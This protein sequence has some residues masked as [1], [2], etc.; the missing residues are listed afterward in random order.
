MTRWPG[1]PGAV[2]LLQQQFRLRRPAGA[3]GDRTG[4]APAALALRGDQ[5]GRRTP[6]RPL[7]HELRRAHQQPALLHG[8]RPPPAAGHGLPQVHRGGPGRA[9]L[10]GLRRRLARPATS[11]TWATRC[12]PTCWRW[13]C[14]EAWEVF[15]TGGGSRVV[16]QRGPGHAAGPAEG[17]G[18]GPASRRASTPRRPR[19]T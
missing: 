8:L 19:A 11:P 4:P 1:I 7:R 13:P 6:V 12:G 3:A 18:A 16:V 9:D 10:R 14:D 17:P 15:N 2:R 5:D